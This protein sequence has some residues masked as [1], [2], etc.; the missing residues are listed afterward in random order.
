MDDRQHGHWIFTERSDTTCQN[1]W[2]IVELIGWLKTKCSISV[3]LWRALLDGYSFR[4]RF[5]SQFRPK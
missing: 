1:H 2:A 5:I 3:T 4:T